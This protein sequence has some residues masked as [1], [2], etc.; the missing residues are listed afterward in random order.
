[1]SKKLSLELFWWLFTAIVAACVLLPI[2]STLNNYPFLIPNLVFIIIFITFTRYIFLLEHTFLAYR[3]LLK[4]AIIFICLG[5]FFYLVNGINAFQTFL[6][7]EGPDMLVREL[8]TQKQKGMANY[9]H[10]EYLFFGVGSAIST[11]I[12]PFR[13]LISI[14]R[15]HNRGT[16]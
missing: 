2:I 15:V 4:I 5:V 3:Q 1:M 13:L 12:L 11:V 14:W 8:T 6:D 16:V 10:S 9:I 7:E